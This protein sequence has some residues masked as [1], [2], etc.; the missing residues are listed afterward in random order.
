MEGFDFLGF[1]IQ[2]QLKRGSGKL[3]VYTKP[4]KT[5]LARVKAKVKA[6]TRRGYNQSLA[7]SLTRSASV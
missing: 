2:R 4:S 1:R 7:R 5:S 3:T 6:A